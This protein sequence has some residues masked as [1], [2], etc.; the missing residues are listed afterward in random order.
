MVRSSGNVPDPNFQ[1]QILRTQS[2]ET[3]MSYAYQSPNSFYGG[4]L[5]PLGAKIGYSGPNGGVTIVNENGLLLGSNSYFGTFYSKP[6]GP[7][8]PF[9]K[10]RLARAVRSRGMR[11]FGSKTFRPSN[12]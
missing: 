6:I 1:I 10:P 2:G 4:N 8:P 5:I 11:T 3:L 7:L 9:A 12:L